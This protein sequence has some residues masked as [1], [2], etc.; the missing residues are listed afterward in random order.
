MNPRSQKG[1]GFQQPFYKRVLALPVRDFKLVPQ[2]RVLVA[3]LFTRF[4]QV[5]VFA[6]KLAFNAHTL[7]LSNS[8]LVHPVVDNSVIRNSPCCTSLM[9]T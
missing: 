8:T 9:L 2:G 7:S 6:L 3:K 4:M 5:I 1:K